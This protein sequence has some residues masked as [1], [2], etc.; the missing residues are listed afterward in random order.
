MNNLIA[1]INTFLSYFITFAVFVLVMGI[2]VFC[3]ITFRKKKNEQDALETQG[4]VEND[5]KE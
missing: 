3:G 1:F 5:T 2:A 4:I